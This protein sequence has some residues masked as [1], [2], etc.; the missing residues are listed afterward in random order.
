MKMID[1]TEREIENL[2]GVYIKDTEW[3]YNDHYGGYI[4]HRIYL[5]NNEEV[6]SSL[7]WEF[8]GV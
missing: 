3:S 8:Q 7:N 1:K 6:I 4:K 2:G 5:L